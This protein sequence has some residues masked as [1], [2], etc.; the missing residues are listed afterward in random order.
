[1]FGAEHRPAV[2][3]RP[4]V[5]DAVTGAELGRRESG[6]L[7]EQRTFDQVQHDVARMLVPH[8]EVVVGRDQV[9]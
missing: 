5:H 9:S 8:V 2:R 6:E 4:G 1:M 7:H 3:D